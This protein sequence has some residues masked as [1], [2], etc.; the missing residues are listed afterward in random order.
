MRES[1]RSLGVSAQQTS[2]LPPLAM[3]TYSRFR[4]SVS[5]PCPAALS[6]ERRHARARRGVRL[7]ARAARGPC[8]GWRSGSRWRIG[9]MLPVGIGPVRFPADRGRN[10]PGVRRKGSLPFSCWRLRISPPSSSS[11]FSQN[12]STERRLRQRFCWR[13][14]LAGTRG[15]GRARSAFSSS[16]RS[17]RRSTK[18]PPIT[19]TIVTASSPIPTGPSTLWTC[20]PK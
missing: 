14:S 10:A 20:L 12:R 7:Q 5:N 9:A 11:V 8:G 19:T 13:R 18:K 6:G 3:P 1:D 2:V 4:R 15:P 16:C 17:W